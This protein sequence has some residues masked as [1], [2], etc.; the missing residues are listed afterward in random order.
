MTKL[1]GR[2]FLPGL[3]GVQHSKREDGMTDQR[4]DMGGGEK[5]SIP[6]PFRDGASLS[7]Q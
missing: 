3:R 1:S 2:A 6:C 4:Q 5:E 7:Q